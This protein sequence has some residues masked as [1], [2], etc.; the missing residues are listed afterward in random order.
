VKYTSDGGRLDIFARTER[1]EIVLDVR[2]TGLGIA[3]EEIDDLFNRFFS[4][5]G[6]R[7]REALGT[8]LGLYI[9]KQIVDG[10]DGSINVVSVPGRGSTFTMRL[11]VR[12]K[13]N[14]RRAADHGDG[15]ADGRAAGVHMVAP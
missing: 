4:A 15:R 10:H 12:P 11:P 5:S 14:G 1:G 8:G 2:D 7:R 9:V 6:V 3:P 13:R